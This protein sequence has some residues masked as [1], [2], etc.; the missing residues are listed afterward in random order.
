MRNFLTIGTLCAGL[1]LAANAKVDQAKAKVK[2]GK[3]DE[4]ITLLE[5]EQKA[6]PKDAAVKAALGQ[7]HMAYGDFFMNN[8]Q[9][10]PF[11]KYP[12]ALRQYRAVLQYEPNNK[13]AKDNVA[14]IEDIYKQMGREVPK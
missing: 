7:T 5:A 13:K 3:Y 10:P 8:D 14:L 4:A 2:E 1:L 9:M 6:H 11:R 12:G